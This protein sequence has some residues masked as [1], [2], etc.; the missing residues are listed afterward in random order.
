VLKNP[1][2][3]FVPFEFVIGSF[4]MGV[5]S[6]KRVAVSFVSLSL[7]VA[8]CLCLLLATERRA[9]AY[10]DPGQGLIA[11]QSIGAVMAASV[12]YLRRRILSLFGKGQ[13]AKKS[14]ANGPVPVS[15]QKGNSRNAA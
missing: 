3:R 1:G 8:F 12:F 4:A 14:V 7:S 2:A 6:I 9:L 5:V 10:V 13:P 11:L 15:V